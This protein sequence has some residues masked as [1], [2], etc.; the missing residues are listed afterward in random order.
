M[1]LVNRI[2]AD[3]PNTIFDVMSQAAR[4]LNAINLGQGF[5][6]DPGPLDVREKAADAVLNG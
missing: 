6:E 4:D 5:P 3:L 2:F 1:I